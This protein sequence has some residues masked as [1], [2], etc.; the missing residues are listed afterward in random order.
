MQIIDYI[1]LGMVAVWITASI[2]FLKKKKKSG[3]C[4]GCSCDCCNKC[5]KK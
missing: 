5:P 2:L 4:L 1:L 3:S